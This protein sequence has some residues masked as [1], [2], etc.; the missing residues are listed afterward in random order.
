MTGQDHI[1]RITQ[2]LTGG[3]VVAVNDVDAAP[4]ASEAQ[5]WRSLEE[6]LP[7]FERE[8][9]RLVL[10]PHPDDFVEDGQACRGGRRLAMRDHQGQPAHDDSH[11]RAGREDRWQADA[12]ADQRAHAE[13]GEAVTSLVKGDDAACHHRLAARQFALPEADLER[14][15][16]PAGDQ[17]HHRGQ[18][19]QQAGHAYG[20]LAGAPGQARPEQAGA[21][22]RGD[23]RRAHLR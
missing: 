1:R 6:L 15:H 5:F 16:Q 14:Q 3:A 17:Q 13:R 10:E 4:S 2:V 9:I 7:V 8:G 22:Q 23:D 18:I 19:G 12:R 11:G 21:E 20:L